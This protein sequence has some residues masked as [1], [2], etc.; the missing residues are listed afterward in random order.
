MAQGGAA[1]AHGPQYPHS[2]RTPRPCCSWRLRVQSKAGLRAPDVTAE[3]R[4]SGSPWEGQVAGSLEEA[5]VGQGQV[6]GEGGKEGA[7]RLA[8][9]CP[10][11]P[12]C[13]LPPWASAEIPQRA[14]E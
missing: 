6:G 10:L 11:Y 7:D 13:P 12:G 3:T 5:G 4:G 8:S 9:P 2:S 14:W 1:R